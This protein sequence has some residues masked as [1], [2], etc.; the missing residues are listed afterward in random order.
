MIAQVVAATVT[1][2]VSQQAHPLRKSDLIRLLSGS[3]FSQD[4]IAGMVRRTCLS[5]AP[6]GRDRADFTAL[7]ASAAVLK[8]I[9]TCGRKTTALPGAPLPR[10][11]LPTTSLPV[12]PH[13]AGPLPVTPPP[14]TPIPA[15]PHPAPNR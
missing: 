15:T 1:L 5:F 8:E 2:L 10:K 13:P 11:A 12:T 14:A 7:G 9:D 6:S 3:T 4:E